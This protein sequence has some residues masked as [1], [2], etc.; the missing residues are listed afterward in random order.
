MVK[1]WRMDTEP[2]PR[3]PLIARDYAF[4]LGTPS[5][6]Y[7]AGVLP[8]VSALAGRVDDIELVL[9]E[10]D[11]GANMPSDRDLTQLAELAA[12]GIL[13]DCVTVW[14]GNILVREDAAAAA[15]RQA[16]FLDALAAAADEVV[17]VAAGL[18]LWLKGKAES[19]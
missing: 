13:L 7:P 5:Y 8:N 16:R 1:T 3:L 18:P 2:L 15:G 19:F 11:N 10:S 12:D 9:F 4:R 6:V 14:L 17:L